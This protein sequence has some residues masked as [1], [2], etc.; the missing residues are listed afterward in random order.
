MTDTHSSLIRDFIHRAMTASRKPRDLFTIFAEVADLLDVVESRAATDD[1][2]KMVIN[3]A[4][5]RIGEAM[6]LIGS[7]RD[8]RQ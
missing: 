4:R 2:K 6:E 5:D 7:P 8:V 1:I 3:I